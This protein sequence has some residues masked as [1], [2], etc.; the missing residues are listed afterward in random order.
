MSTESVVLSP[1]LT[2]SDRLILENLAHDIRAHYPAQ[3]NGSIKSADQP[4]KHGNGA[5]NG[6]MLAA[7]LKPQCIDTSNAGIP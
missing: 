1:E 5:A 4:A 6:G 2:P 7:L 3:S